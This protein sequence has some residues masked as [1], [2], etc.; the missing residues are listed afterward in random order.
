ME[1][2]DMAVLTATPKRDDGTTLAR[3]IAL[4]FALQ[5]HKVTLAWGGTLPTGE[6]L[7]LVM[8]N[9][10]VSRRNDV[11]SSRSFMAKAVLVDGKAR[12]FSRVSSSEWCKLAPTIPAYDKAVQ[13]AKARA[14]ASAK[15]LYDSRCANLAK[16]RE[17]RSARCA[18]RARSATSRAR[19]CSNK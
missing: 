18:S 15:A 13:D 4:R 7:A 10:I 14:I 17:I 19:V 11:V 6:A 2:R 5:G 8:Y 3:G 9:G 1:V 16:A 12:G